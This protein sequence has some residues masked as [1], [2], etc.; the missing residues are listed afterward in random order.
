MRCRKNMEQECVSIISFLGI[1]WDRLGREYAPSTAAGQMRAQ[2]AY[3]VM[4]VSHT[5]MGDRKGH[6]VTG[7]QTTAVLIPCLNEERTIG[8]VVAAFR[9][10]LPDAQIYVYDNASDDQ[11]SER[12]AQAGAIVRMAP[13]RGKGNV[14]RR[15]LRNID[16]DR[17]VLV[18]GDDTYPAQDVHAL[19]DA[20][21]NG[22]DMVSGTGCP[23]LTSQRTSGV[24]T[25]PATASCAA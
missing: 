5:C 23:P 7:N 3:L 21:D 13:E 15:M 11:T 6:T 19:L 2:L 10:E 18:D 17:Y 4:R 20:L 22:W 9:R 8:K 1:E 24:S 14:L 16:A 12:A 25:S